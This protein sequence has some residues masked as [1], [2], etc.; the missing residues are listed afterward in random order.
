MPSTAISTC[1]TT[2]PVSPG[3]DARYRSTA[4]MPASATTMSTFGGNRSA[5]Q[6]PQKYITTATAP[7]TDVT[8]P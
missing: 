8:S 2:T 1:A 3:T 7:N 5:N 4:P 6:P